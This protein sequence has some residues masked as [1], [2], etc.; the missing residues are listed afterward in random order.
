[1]RVFKNKEFSRYVRRVG[2]LDA[3]LC[4]A[5][6]QV[7]RGLIDAD[8]GSGVIKQRVARTGGGKS[9][10]FRTIILF[11]VSTLAIFVY[12]F[13]KNERSNIHTNELIAFKLLAAE[14][15]AYDAAALAKAVTA[16]AF[17]EV[18]CKADNGDAV[19]EARKEADETSI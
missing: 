3:A 11:K 14:V 2:I 13:A 4:Y 12:G 18:F 8:L 16:G 10:G 6:S 17:T 1:M 5:V 15:L 9:G 7:D 19:D